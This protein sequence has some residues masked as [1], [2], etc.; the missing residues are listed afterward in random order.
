MR[1]KD[2]NAE[3]RPREK[4]LAR[5]AGALTNAELLA[6]FVGSGCGGRNAVDVAQELLSS[7]GGRLT[8]LCRRSPRKLM[9]HKGIGEARA[10]AMAAALELGRRYLAEAAAD[11]AVITGPG[12]VARMMAPLMKGLDHEECWVLYLNRANN[13]LDRERVT[14]GTADATL[15]DAKQILRSVI[16]RQAKAVILV[17]NHPSGSPLPGEADIRA[18]RQLQLALKTFDVYL[19]DH[20]IFSDGAYYSFQDER[21]GK[22]E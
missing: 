8:E 11:R 4:L 15:F 2:W 20:V 6:V 1:L 17:H 10:V 7:A 18:T 5:G 19:F 14:S 16:E 3:E 21:V 12:D 22:S 9:A 13:V